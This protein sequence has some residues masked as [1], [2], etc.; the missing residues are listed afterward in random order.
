MVHTSK[1]RWSTQTALRI[2]S[3]L[4]ATAGYVVT[5]AYSTLRHPCYYVAKFK[6]SSILQ[7]IHSNRYT[8]RYTET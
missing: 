2:N 6:T 4:T 1:T 7:W 3:I 8:N 5:Q